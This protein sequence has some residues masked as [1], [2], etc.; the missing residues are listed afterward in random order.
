MIHRNT[1]IATP[2]TLYLADHRSC[3]LIDA[4]SGEVKDEIVVPKG[5]SDGPVWKWMALA[6]GVLYA[7]VGGSEVEISTQ[8]SR[9]PGLGHWPWGMWEGHDYKDPR[10]AFGFGRTLVAVDLE[11]KKV[12]WHYRDDEFL[13]AR[14]VVVHRSP[15]R[16]LE[17]ADGRLTT[18]VEAYLR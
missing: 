4:A 8:S 3:K 10:T 15:P 5:V 6:D 17:I 11:T 18:L 2:E 16:V 12:L 9:T 13:D 14:G 7:L 1:M